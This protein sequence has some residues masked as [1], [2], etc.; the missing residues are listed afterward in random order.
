VSRF[1]L[2]TLCILRATLSYKLQGPRL[3]P[4]ITGVES[5]D[6]LVLPGEPVCVE[7]VYEEGYRREVFAAGICFVDAA[8]RHGNDEF[9]L[10]VSKPYHCHT[11]HVKSPGLGH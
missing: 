9:L 5:P 11:C 7:P 1:A 2:G 8:E 3:P 4:V 6:T 10:Q